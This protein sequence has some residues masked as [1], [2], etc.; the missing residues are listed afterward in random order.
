MLIFG[1][2]SYSITKMLKSSYIV[3]P[4]PQQNNEICDFVDQTA[5][6]LSKK[7]Q[8][9]VLKIAKPISLRELLLK[10]LSHGNNESAGRK[11]R[12]Q[13]IKPL[14]FLPF[15]RF[16]FVTNANYLLFNLL[17]QS[18]LLLINLVKSKSI[19]FWFFFPETYHFVF[20]QSWVHFDCVDIHSENGRLPRIGGK[21]HKLLNRTDTISCIA[22]S[23]K[24]LLQT[25]TNK[26]IQLV[27]QGFAVPTIER[28]IATRHFR[29]KTNPVIGFAGALSDRIDYDLI[30]DLALHNPKWRFE[31]W[32]PAQAF[33]TNLD[34]V[35][36]NIN[37]LKRCKNINMM[38]NTTR[39]RLY[40]QMMNFDIGIIP[41]KVN[42]VLNQYCYPMKLIEYFFC[43]IP[44]VATPIKEVKNFPKLVKIASNSKDWEWAIKFTLSK[45]W[46]KTNQFEQ[47]RI[48]KANTWELKVNTILSFINKKMV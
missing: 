3:L 45:S 21:L 33:F 41:Y 15:T 42:N 24:Q 12:Y 23:Q 31:L 14:F 32:G 20:P 37:Q 2:I 13:V 35:N 36:S 29:S 22:K 5:I 19:I 47:L 9:I 28:K 1:R 30:L 17:L 16:R 26:T 7:H 34:Q 39:V 27:P 4:D 40:Q 44:T 11:C 8:V 25:M 10:L 46:S 6:E 43:G 38:G 18:Y 48:S